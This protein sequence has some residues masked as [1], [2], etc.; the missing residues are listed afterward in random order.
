MDRICQINKNGTVLFHPEVMDLCPELSI[1]KPEDRLFIVLAFDYESIW[2]QL[3]DNDRILKA[4]QRC[5]NSTDRK[6]VNTQVMKNA[7]NAYNSCQYNAKRETMKTYERKLAFLNDEISKDIS[8]L[9]LKKLLES[10]KMIRTAMQ[11]MQTEMYEQ[12]E[13]KNTIRGGG[14]LSFIE[15]V[16]RNKAEYERIK[17]KHNK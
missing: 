14:T 16:M 7:I 5:Y 6:I 10:Q 4:L 1:L 12:Q 9:E 17:N 3:N 13:I 11:E 2:H 8:S 15:D